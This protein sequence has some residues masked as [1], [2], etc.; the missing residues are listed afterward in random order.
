MLC[1]RTTK[2]CALC[3]DVGWRVAAQ[4]FRVRVPHATPLGTKLRLPGKGDET[5][6]TTRERADLLVELAAPGE[7]AEELR[8]AQVA[9]EAA[10]DARFAKERKAASVR[11]RHERRAVRVSAL[12]LI[13]A[14]V[15]LAGAWFKEGYLDKRALGASCGGNRDCR[16]G[17]CLAI[18]CAGSALPGSTLR[19]QTIEAHVC[20][21]ACQTDAGCPAAMECSSVHDTFSGFPFATNRPPDRLACAPRTSRTP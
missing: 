10:L 7:R 14:V 8:S 13:T 1:V 18:A 15:L 21:H 20:T 3:H 17:E 19:P 4:T 2:R 9:E 11:G 12:I 16:S 5:S 6:E